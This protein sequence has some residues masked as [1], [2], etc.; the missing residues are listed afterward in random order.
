MLRDFSVTR[1]EPEYWKSLYNFTLEEQL[2]PD[3][4]MANWYVS[5][6]P[7]SRLVNHLTVARTAHDGRHVLFDNEFGV[8]CL[9]GKTERHLITADT[10]LR[11]ILLDP[12]GLDLP[13][14][15]EPDVVL[16]RLSRLPRRD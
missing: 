14:S 7:Q 3:Y 11:E 16:Q 4:E 10:N 9:N 13:A 12:I 2:V 5:C 1:P 6:H 8:H 15:P